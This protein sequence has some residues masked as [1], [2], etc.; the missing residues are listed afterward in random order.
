MPPLSCP[1]DPSL[2]F[3]CPLNPSQVHNHTPPP[4]ARS[5]PPQWHNTLGQR[6][7]HAPGSSESRGLWLKFEKFHVTKPTTRREEG[8]AR[9]GV[10]AMKV[11]IGSPK[12]CSEPHQRQ[13]GLWMGGG[14]W[15]GMGTF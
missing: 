13:R 9:G 5:E 1:R 6:R 8:R 2:S 12:L 14:E 10:G 4:T 11:T 15:R 7:D 3:S